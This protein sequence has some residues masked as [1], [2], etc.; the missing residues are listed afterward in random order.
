[1]NDGKIKVDILINNAGVSLR[2]FV[3]NNPFE[4]D[5][6]IMNVNYLSQVAITKVHTSYP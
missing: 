5:I 4:N 2:S 1:M 3:L 6:K